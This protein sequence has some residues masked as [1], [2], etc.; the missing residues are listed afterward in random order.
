LKDTG[1][2]ADHYQE[3]VKKLEGLV[4]IFQEIQSIPAVSSNPTLINAIHGQAQQSHKTIKDFLKRIDKYNAKLGRNSKRGFHHGTLSKVKW[5][6]I[7]SK[8]VGR[9]DEDVQGHSMNLML[10]LSV[11]NV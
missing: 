8:E 1:G 7:I 9:F 2:A 11:L 10:L 5:V 4:A 3:V 6:T